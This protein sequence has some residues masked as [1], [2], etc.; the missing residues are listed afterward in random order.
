M[1]STLGSFRIAGT[2]SQRVFVQARTSRA[3]RVSPDVPFSI[4]KSAKMK[5]SQPLLGWYLI[6]NTPLLLLVFPS[7]VLLGNVLNFKAC[8]ELPE[9][10]ERFVS[11]SLREAVE[12]LAGIKLAFGPKKEAEEPKEE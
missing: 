1:N 5:P 3:F 9:E 7:K 4:M 6:E 11:R 12:K 10:L 2:E 8:E